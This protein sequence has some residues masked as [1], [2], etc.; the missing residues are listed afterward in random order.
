LELGIYV[1]VSTGSV[2][3][4]LV[5]YASTRSIAARADLIPLDITPQEFVKY[6]NTRKDDN[7]PVYTD[8]T[9]DIPEVLQEI[10][11]ETTTDRNI[12]IPMAE[13]MNEDETNKIQEP[14]TE[15]EPLKSPISRKK[16]RNY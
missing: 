8:I 11:D 9:F 5:Y 10:Q 1:G 2:C 4:G 14:L 3:G 7:I 15:P 6:E 12:N 16:Q 13:D